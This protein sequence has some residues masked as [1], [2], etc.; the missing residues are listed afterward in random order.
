MLVDESPFLFALGPALELSLPRARAESKDAF[1]P[2]FDIPSIGDAWASSGV[3]LVDPLLYVTH[4]I[5][6]HLHGAKRCLYSFI[7]YSGQGRPP[8]RCVLV[9]FKRKSIAWRT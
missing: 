1:D 7:V 6:Q 3:G 9:L 4:E 8:Q 2:N 5:V